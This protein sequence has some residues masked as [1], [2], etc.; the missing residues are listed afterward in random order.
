[1]FNNFGRKFTEWS[2]YRR[3]YNE[4]SRLSNREL[5][6]LGIARMDIKSIARRTNFDA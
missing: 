6:D 4:L 3:T 2:G 1:M 5:D